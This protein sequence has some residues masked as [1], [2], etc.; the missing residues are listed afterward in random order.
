M[1]PEDLN[2]PAVVLGAVLGFALG[3]I[4]YHPKVFGRVW[5]EGSGVDLGGSPPVAAFIL[6]VLALVA[7]AMVIGLTATIS[8]LFTAIFAILAAT[9]FV[10][11]GGA[12]LRKSAGAL[13]VDGGYVLG[14]GILMIV[15]QGIL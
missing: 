3:A 14:A 7:L 4:L 9:F 11:S 5:A 15:A 1:T 10:V 13:L 6:Q 12:F 8:A 2:I